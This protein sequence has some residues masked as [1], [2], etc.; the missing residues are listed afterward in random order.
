M[1]AKVNGKLLSLLLKMILNL[2]NLTE[3]MEKQLSDQL[4]YLTIS[5]IDEE[6]G[7]VV[8]TVGYQFIPPKGNYPL[9][10]HPD[11]YNFK[12]QTGRIL[13]EYQLVYITK[14][15]GYFSSQSCKMQKINA[16]TMILL[17]RENGTATIPTARQAG[18]N[19]GSVSA[20]STSTGAWKNAFLPARNR[21]ST[22]GSVRRSSD[23]MK[24]Y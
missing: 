8:T 5:A 12:P 4:R 23:Y 10:K 2:S 20:V 15:S 16:G 14:G 11:N 18:T 24:T 7:I 13:N 19:T 17:F 3:E 21:Y 6:W 22:S 1:I 9:S